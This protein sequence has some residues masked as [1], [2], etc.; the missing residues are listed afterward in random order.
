MNSVQKTRIST[1]GQV[2]IPKQFRDKFNIHPGDEV[3]LMMTDEGILI[4]PKLVRTNALRGLLKDEI[5][6][7]KASNFISEE[8]KKWRV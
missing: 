6:V 3:V 1:K 7:E 8:R 2:T 5:D 4:K